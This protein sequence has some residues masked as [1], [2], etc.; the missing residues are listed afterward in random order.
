MKRLALIVALGLLCSGCAL[1]Y[2]FSP[3]VAPPTMTPGAKEGHFV[4]PVGP[5][6]TSRWEFLG[7]QYRAWSGPETI[8]F[9]SF[10]FCPGGYPTETDLAHC[11]QTYWGVKVDGS[12]SRKIQV[13]GRML[14]DW[15]FTEKEQSAWR[16]ID[17]GPPSPYNM[18]GS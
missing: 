14:W 2:H 18:G 3:D 8:A 13:D 7:F 17:L 5:T 15:V 12:E 16:I 10:S 1:K 6:L 9:Y 4:S 11:W